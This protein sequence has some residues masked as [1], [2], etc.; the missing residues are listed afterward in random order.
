M[1][2]TNPPEGVEYKTMKVLFH[3]KG[4]YWQECYIWIVD[5][6]VKCKPTGR[7]ITSTKGWEND[8]ITADKRFRPKKKIVR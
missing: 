7:Q 4:T 3:D 5:H 2:L 8:K 1:G 6:Q